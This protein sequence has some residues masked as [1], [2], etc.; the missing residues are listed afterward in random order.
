MYETKLDPDSLDWQ[1]LD[2]EGVAIRVLHGDPGKGPS[3]IL[4]RLDPN[5][6]IPAHWHS[7]ADETVYVVEG[8]L[9]EDGERFP[10]GT[11]FA[12]RCKTGHGPHRTDTGCL[13]LTTFSNRLDFN[14]SSQHAPPNSEL[15]S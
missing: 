15:E 12:G 5:C 2:F 14:L 4:T 10:A 1:P 7:Q 13:M 9:I 11:F 8:E 6:E 3:T